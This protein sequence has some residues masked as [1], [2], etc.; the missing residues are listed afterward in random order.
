MYFDLCLAPSI[1]FALLYDLTSIILRTKMEIRQQRN[2][3]EITPFRALKWNERQS[4][5]ARALFFWRSPC[6]LTTNSVWPD[7][8]RMLIIF[9]GF[10][11]VNN[12]RCLDEIVES[13]FRLIVASF[14]QSSVCVCVCFFLLMYKL[15]LWS[16]WGVMAIGDWYHVRFSCDCIMAIC[17]WCMGSFVYGGKGGAGGG[18]AAAIAVAVVVADGTVADKWC[19]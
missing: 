12:S 4:E 13:N 14:T 7:N 19:I 8:Y 15:Y 18:G 1:F 10:Y 17:W 6:N 16:D 3:D 5:W 2:E 11:W 9:N